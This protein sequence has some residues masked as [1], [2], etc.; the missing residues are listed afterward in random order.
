MCHLGA[1][2]RFLD[3]KQAAYTVTEM[4]GGRQHAT[5]LFRRLRTWKDESP[6]E[7]KYL[8]NIFNGGDVTVKGAKM[9]SQG[10]ESILSATIGEALRRATGP[11]EIH[12]VS[13]F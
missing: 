8:L 10:T 2:V 6:I 7:R 9:C 13:A 3:G 4:I 5:R 11:R 1:D 12:S